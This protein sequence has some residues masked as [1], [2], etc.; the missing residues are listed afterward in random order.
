M[1]FNYTD[2]DTVYSEQPVEQVLPAHADRIQAQRIFLVASRSLAEATKQFAAL[3]SSLGERFV[4]ISAAIRSHTPREDVLAV[5]AQ[6]REAEADL[7]VSLGGGSVIDACKAIQLGLSEGLETAEDFLDYAQRADGSRGDRHGSALTWM[8]VPQVSGSASSLMGVPQIRPQIRQVAVPTTLSGAEF[9]NNAGVLDSVANAKE[10]YRAPGLCPQAIIY[11]PALTLHT[12]EWL[13]LSTAI[14]SLDHAIEGFCSADTSSYHDGQ[15]LHAIR[16][17]AES[18]PLT[19]SAPDNL[20]ARAMNQ[21]AVWSACCGLGTVSH[22]ASHG[23]GY[24]LGSLH[25]V[26]HGHTSCVMLPAVLQWNEDQLPDRMQQIAL[27]LGAEQGGAAEAVRELIG[28]L[29]LPTS[30]QALGI[31]KESLDEIAARASKHPVVRKNPK[32]VNSAGQVR[33]ILEL[34]WS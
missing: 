21:T 26:P 33:E 29:G 14:R 7:L 15:F 12:P 34:A 30:L 3:R 32:P 5:L 6:V 13:F 20:Q 18:L 19:K 24:I 28:S 2:L 16:L 22:G 9:S 23:I 10:G 31:E 8:G 1:Q 27:A 25:G 17:F 4:G 11:D